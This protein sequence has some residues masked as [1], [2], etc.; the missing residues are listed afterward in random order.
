LLVALKHQAA[1]QQRKVTPGW[2][3]SVTFRN[4]TA[5]ALRRPERRITSFVDVDFT[6][7]NGTKI[8]F[9]ANVT[10]FY[11][12]RRYDRAG[13]AIQDYLMAHAFGFNFGRHFGGACGRNWYPDN[14]DAQMEMIEMMGLQEDLLILDE[15]PTND[16]SAMVLD[17]YYYYMWKDTDVWTREWIEYMKQRRLMDQQQEIGDKQQDST[18]VVHIRRGDVHPCDN[19]TLNRYL[20]NS[21]YIALINQYRPSPQ[22]RVIVHSEQHSRVEPWTD[23]EDIDG[24]EFKL[25]TDPVETWRDILEAEVFIMSISSFSLVPAL[26]SK[27]SKVI[28]TQF[29]HRPQPD[30]IR[31]DSTLLSESAAQTTL[32]RENKC[33]EI[34]DSING[35]VKVSSKKLRST[36]K[37]RS[38]IPPNCTRS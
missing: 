16:T 37:V 8:L 22:S 32:L 25:D 1:E 14:H 18:V 20:P 23:F 36:W 10:H 6:M 17:Q 15:C 33:T 31:V 26:F 4:S 34:F 19:Y 5:P 27:A 3:T 38:C 9:P 7:N 12:N 28:Y 35:P 2:T 21:H 24:I 13:S 30:W 11:C 29:W